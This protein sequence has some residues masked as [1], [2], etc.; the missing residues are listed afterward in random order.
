MGEWG[1]STLNEGLYRV[2]MVPGAIRWT[3]RVAAAF[4]SLKGSVWVF[5]FD[6][7]GRQ[8]ALSWKYVRGQELGV[9]MAAPGTGDVLEIPAT[10]IEFHDSV[11]VDQAD[12]A[13]AEP[14]FEHWRATAEG[15][16]LG[17]SECV[18]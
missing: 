15:R 6:W 8:F 10:F 7:L 18:G 14:F 17:D 12:A 13:L 4:P 16:A 9:V 3:E 1:G 2:H 11:L 5:G